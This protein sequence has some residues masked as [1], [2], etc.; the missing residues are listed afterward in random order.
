MK[1]IPVVSHAYD[2]IIGTVG[3]VGKREVVSL[4]G[5]LIYIYILRE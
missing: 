5:A 3:L 2:F 4:V 1:C